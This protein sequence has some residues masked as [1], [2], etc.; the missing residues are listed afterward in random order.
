MRRAPYTAARTAAKAPPRTTTC[1]A[2]GCQQQVN[3]PLLMCVDHWRRVPAALR[4][5]VWAAYQRIGRD[6]DGRQAHLD[7]VKAAVQAVHD[8]A[9]ASKTKRDAVTP[10]LFG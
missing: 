8:K 7:A 6:A 1:A 2:I 5:Q 9:L 3:V 4:R 10:D